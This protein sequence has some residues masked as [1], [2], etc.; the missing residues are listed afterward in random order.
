[1][2]SQSAHKKTQPKTQPPLRRIS[3]KIQGSRVYPALQVIGY[4][5]AFLLL[6]LLGNLFR[7]AVFGVGVVIVYG[8]AAV[9]FRIKSDVTFKLALLALIYVLIMASL[10]NQL[11]VENFSQS[12][13]MLLVFGT[14]CSFLEQ[15]HENKMKR[16]V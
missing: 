8:V 7:S 16:K 12:A 15:W 5:G 10:K 6:V 13:F 2:T 3:A 11:L 14:L 9:L 4:A 1:M